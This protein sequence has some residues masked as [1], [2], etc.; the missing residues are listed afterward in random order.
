M[1]DQVAEP[2]YLTRATQP[3]ATAGTDSPFIFVGE[4]LALDLVNTEVVIRRRPLDLLVSSG[5]Y[6]TWWRAAA[7]RH[8]EAVARLPATAVTPRPDVLAD[9]LVLRGALRALFGAAAD[10]MPLPSDAVT[11][12]NRVLGGVHD[13]IAPGPGRE[14]RAVLVSDE[15]GVDGPLAAVARSAFDLLTGSDLS[16]LHRC[17]N[18]HCVLLFYDTTKSATRRWCSTACMNRARSSERFRAR[19]AASK[20][21]ERPR[22]AVEKS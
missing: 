18:N 6:E 5:R 14:P 20:E 9:V 19:Q 12:L 1:P 10:G 3:A 22:R 11:V 16:R 21:N 8:P 7:E 2:D 4:A 13:A 15:T 17:A